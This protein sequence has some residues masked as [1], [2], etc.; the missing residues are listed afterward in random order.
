LQIPA[1]LI[2]LKNVAV[3]GVHWGAYSKNE[4]KK[5]PET[6]EAL[7]KLFAEKRIKGVVYD[8]VFE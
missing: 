3:T 7:L 1:N 4:I 2:L 6:W 5:V 8:K